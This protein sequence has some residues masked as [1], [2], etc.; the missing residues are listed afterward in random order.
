V[1]ARRRSEADNVRV[2]DETTSVGP[3]RY[4]LELTPAQLK[5]THTA[6]HALLN[7]FGHEQSDVHGVV[8]EVLE[9]LPDEHAMRAIRLDDELE[10]E[11]HG[12]S[13]PA[14]ETLADDDGPGP[15]AA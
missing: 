7:D 5:I 12:D 13:S 9:K 10:R 4:H 11:L 2:S 15:P 3:F 14:L 6:L 1:L 8:R